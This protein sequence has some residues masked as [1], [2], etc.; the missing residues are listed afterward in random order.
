MNGGAGKKTVFP[1]AKWWRSRKGV[2]RKMRM[3]KRGQQG[4]ENV[5]KT[6]V[7]R[8]ECGK[9]VSG[10]KDLWRNDKRRKSNGID[11]R[12]RE[13]CKLKREKN[14]LHAPGGTTSQSDQLASRR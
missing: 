5:E 14:D 2:I 11:S 4:D 3:R 12:D 9:D 10:K 7:G 8:R 6:S 1:V 13:K